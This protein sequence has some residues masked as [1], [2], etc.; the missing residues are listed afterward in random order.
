MLSTF[1]LRRQPTGHRMG[2][3]VLLVLLVL[4][5]LVLLVL[6]LLVLQASSYIIVKTAKVL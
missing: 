4:L 6:L 3:I 5:V 1:Y 2:R